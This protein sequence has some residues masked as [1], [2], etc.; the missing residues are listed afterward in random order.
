MKVRPMGAAL[1]LADGWTDRQT[2]M[3]K[4]IVAFRNFSE[5]PKILRSA[6]TVFMC[7]VFISEQT[8]TFSLQN[9][10]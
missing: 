2:D 3:T 4:L 1:F 7:F 10:K 6:Y 5:A 8:A 9:I